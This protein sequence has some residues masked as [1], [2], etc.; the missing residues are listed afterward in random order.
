ML[1]AGCSPSHPDA[2]RRSKAPF[3][4]VDGKEVFLYTLR[5]N[6]GMEARITNYGGIVVSLLVP[7]K[8]NTPGDIVLGYDSLSSYL[9]ATPYF[10]AIVGRY[11]NRIGRAHFTLDG[12]EYTLNANDGPNTL[13]GGLK[14]FDKVVWDADESTPATKASLTLSYLSKD[15]EEGYPGNLKA[16][17]VYTVTDSNELRIDYA[18]TTDKP[19]VLNLTHHSYFNLAGAGNGDILSHELMLNADKFTP[20]DSGLIT[21]GELKPVEGTPMDF[22]TPTAIGARIAAKDDQLRFGRGYDHNWVLN[23]TGEGLSLAARVTEKTSGRVMEVWTTQPG[24]QFYSGNFL[25]GTNIGKG[26][27]PYAY[28]TG[29]CLETQHFPDSPNKPSFPSTV[30]RPGENFTSTTVYKFSAR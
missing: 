10:G 19:T 3:G 16:T 11:G 5:N 17:V 26:G 25:D 22:R 28:R 8:S 4:S 24:I 2:P 21:T 7:D 15:G 18:A 29:F 12:K 30:L 23:R 6:A 20:I 14:G 27:K 9:K 1:I 13:H